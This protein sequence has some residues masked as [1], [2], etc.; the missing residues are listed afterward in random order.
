MSK[1]LS[2]GSRVLIYGTGGFAK[3][4]A[5]NSLKLGYKPIGFVDHVNVD[6][7]V[8]LNNLEY[9]VFDSQN[10]PASSSYDAILLGIGNGYADLNNIYQKLLRHTP[11]DSIYS[12]VEISYLCGRNGINLDCYWM[13]SNCEFYKDYSREINDT[14]KM[15]EDEKSRLLF[16]QILK[17]R[18]FG[19]LSDLP[20]PGLA[21]EQYLPM[22]LSTPPKNLRML[23][24]GA[25][26]GENLE[27]FLKRGH[28]VDFASFFEPDYSNFVFLA[29]KLRALRIDNSL[30]LP[31]AAWDE[32]KILSFDA[33]SDTSSHLV[34]TGGIFVQSV[35]LSDLLATTSVNYIKMDIEG[36]EYQALLGLE[37]VI[38]RDVPH[39]AISVY[40]KPD[41]MW[42]IGLWLNS[43]FGKQY[44]FYL[45]NYSFQTFETLL[46]A[47]P[48]S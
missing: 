43:K 11:K 36:A 34:D 9:Q 27:F 2:V 22:D 44:S 29:E 1:S 15:F 45:R 6:R 4:V 16:L 37:S 7:P 18:E 42:K 47:I 20:H 48:N 25:C 8:K 24:L 33:S 30:V 39:L 13:Q 32:T 21:S 10:L 26:R 14:L 31:L 23:D 5:V 41:D 19:E 46:Y 35:K 38:K 12:P 28:V 40:H 17:Y 3:R